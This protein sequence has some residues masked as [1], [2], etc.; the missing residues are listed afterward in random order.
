[1]LIVLG[2]G[3]P[4]TQAQ[5]GSAAKSSVCTRPPVGSA[6]PSPIDLRSN[7]R[8]LKLELAFHSE[9]QPDGSVRYCYL[10]EER[11]PSPTLRLHPGDTLLLSLKN[12]AAV[13]R[14]S[15]A[16]AS[17]NH[18]QAVNGCTASSAMTAFTT[19]LHF[20]GMVIA[21]ACHQDETL[22]TLVQPNDVAFEYRI[23][24]PQDAQPGLYWYH[25]HIHGFSKAQVLGGAS[26]ALIIEGLEKVN[27]AVA[28]LPERVL[29]IRDQDL[30]NPNSEPVRSGSVPPPILMKDAEGDIINTGTG[31]GKP[32]KDLSINFVPVPYPEYKPA[33]IPIRPGEKQLWRVLNASA[34]TYLDLQLLY[35]DRPQ[36]VG[37]VAMDGVSVP[38]GKNSV[39]VGA[40][41]WKSHVLLPP[42]GRAELIVKAPASGTAASFVT[43]FVDTGPAGEN[44]PTRP[45]ATLQVSAD[46]PEPASA[47]PSAAPTDR[48]KILPAS[49][50]TNS[51]LQKLWLGNIAP[52]RERKLFFSE[53]PQNPNDPNSPTEFFITV[54]GQPTKVFDPTSDIPN[55]IVHQGDVEDWVIENRSTELHAFHIHQIHFLLLDWNGVPLDEPLLRDTINMPYWDGHSPDYPSLKLRMDFRDPRIVG[56]FPYHCHLLEHE[57]NGMMGLIR[58]EPK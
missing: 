49:F 30:L 29:I 45:L 47:M 51:P 37:V 28:G 58:V 35:G 56:T 6:V 48:A 36:T 24:I 55:I 27:P 14:N 25:P 17:H 34:I 43:R 31:D 9:A 39:G 52:V 15:S 54:E 1:L 41:I 13:S 26:G 3:P 2:A 46:A 19:N 16:A 38:R 44:D 11:V 33:V 32:A 42:A 23:E 57:D 12:E 10:Y 50:K 40:V 4:V 20:H 21:P 8:V 5:T 53:V 7:N 18:S 22:K